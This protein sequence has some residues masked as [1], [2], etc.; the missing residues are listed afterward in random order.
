MDIKIG[1]F[2]KVDGNYASYAIPAAQSSSQ[3]AVPQNMAIATKVKVKCN[4]T[5]AY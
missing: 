5:K 4:P 3:S 2:V 1:T